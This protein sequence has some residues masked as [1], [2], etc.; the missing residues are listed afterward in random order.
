MATYEILV[1][2]DVTQSVS[3][4]VVAPNQT[5]ARNMALAYAPKATSWEPDDV[6]FKP[7]MQV[8]DISY[9]SPGGEPGRVSEELPSRST[10][11]LSDLRAALREAEQLISGDAAGPEWKRT[12][13][14]FVAKARKLLGD[15]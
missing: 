11:S 6:P 14:A 2:R 3:L 8:T 4:V 7:S 10:A 9:L 5:I 1:T 15:A 13:H 12:S